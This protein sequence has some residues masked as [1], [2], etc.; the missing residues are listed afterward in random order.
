MTSLAQ[1]NANRNN[2]KKSTGPKTQMGKKSSSQNALT[3]GIFAQIPILPGEDKEAITALADEITFAY[4]PQDAMELILVERIIMASIRQVRLRDAEAATVKISMAPERIAD[5][6]NSALRVDFMERVTADDLKP[7]MESYYQ[8]YLEV[9]KEIEDSHYLDIKE[10]TIEKIQAIM[11]KAYEF[12]IGKPRSYK[13]DWSDFIKDSAMMKKGI[14]D[15]KDDLEKYIKI[16]KTKHNAYQ[17]IE[18]IKTIHRLPN[19]KEMTRFNKYQTQFDHDLYRAMNALEKYRH[20]KAK[21]IE[22]ELVEDW[23]R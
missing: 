13:M 7:E 9:L 19:E 16:N 11:P 14:R 10:I 17:L 2:A 3:H 8:S 18:D 23:A 15:V 21:I 1:I 5:A 22:G 20:S 6:L 4:K 12:L